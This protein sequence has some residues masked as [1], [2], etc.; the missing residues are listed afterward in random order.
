VFFENPSGILS[1]SCKIASVGII[2]SQFIVPFK[3]IIVTYK[4]YKNNTP[5]PAISFKN[6]KA[7]LVLFTILI[8]F[9]T[10]YFIAIFDILQYL[11]NL[12]QLF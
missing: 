5:I 12:D 3:F 10:G 1:I 2:I 11:S 4:S 7:D 8:L 9:S 6:I